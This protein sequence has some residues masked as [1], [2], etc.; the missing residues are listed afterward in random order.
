MHQTLIVIA[1]ILGLSLIL[2][3]T[4]HMLARLRIEQHRTLQKLI[5]QGASGQELF[6]A[7]GLTPRGDRYR[8]RGILLIALGLAWSMVTYFIGGPA[9]MMGLFPVL[10]GAACLLIWKLDGSGR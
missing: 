9:W 7:A 1:G 6:R 3:V 10:L 8:R 4:I 2:A 5:E